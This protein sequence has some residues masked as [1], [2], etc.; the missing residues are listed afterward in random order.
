[1][2]YSGINFKKLLEPYKKGWVAIS[3]DF[4]KVVV[5]GKSLKEVREKT[6]NYK[7]LLYFFPSGESYTH[8]V[9]FLHQ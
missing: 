6:K 3:Y 5:H 4:K 8:F 1:M 9:G 7:N 2:K